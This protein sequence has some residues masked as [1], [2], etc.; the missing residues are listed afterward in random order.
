MAGQYCRQDPKEAALA[1]TRCPPPLTE[2]VTDAEFLDSDFFDA[3]DAVQVNNEMVRKVRACGTP[4]T[5]AAAAFGDSPPPT[6]P[7]PPR[8]S[9]QGWR[10]WCPPGPGR[11]APTS[12]PSGPRLGRGAAGRRSGRRPA[13]RP[14]LIEEAF[15][16]RVHP[17]SVEPALAR[18]RERHSK[19]R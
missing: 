4:V 3:R 13:H 15:G 5:E 1:A 14:D 2:Q 7:R 16:V 11:A 17:R 19:S 9:R 12:S 8:W 6:T 18:R 10:G